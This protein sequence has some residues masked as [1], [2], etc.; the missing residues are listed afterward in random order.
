MV[1]VL[2]ADHTLSSKSFRTWT[3]VGIPGWKKK[4]EKLSQGAGVA[5]VLVTVVFSKYVYRQE[6]QSHLIPYRDSKVMGD[7]L[8]C[9]G[10]FKVFAKNKNCKK[11]FSERE[12]QKWF[13]R[14]HKK[15]ARPHHSLS[16]LWVT[17]PLGQF[18]TACLGLLLSRSI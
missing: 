7:F 11:Y 12:K 2:F 16:L 8:L 6:T 1:P 10:C 13:I 14:S 3:C 9:V 5:R 18:Q 15:L 4:K 17:A